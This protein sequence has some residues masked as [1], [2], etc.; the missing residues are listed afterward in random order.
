[1]KLFIV[2]RHTNVM[3]IHENGKQVKP[4]WKTRFR[5]VFEREELIFDPVQ[6]ANGKPAPSKDDWAHAKLGAYVFKRSGW[7]I[8]VPGKDVIVA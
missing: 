2:P 5:N 4:T 8:V 6:L 7:K 1:M 3:L